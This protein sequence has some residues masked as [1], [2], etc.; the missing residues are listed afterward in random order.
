MGPETWVKMV[1]Q[2]V[3]LMQSP[4]TL[5]VLA[6]IIRGSQAAQIKT[7]LPDICS[8]LTDPSICNI[9]DVSIIDGIDV[10]NKSSLVSL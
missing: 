5:Q 2:Q 10:F 1:L 8:I 3:K 9:A 6:A 7:Y 4:G